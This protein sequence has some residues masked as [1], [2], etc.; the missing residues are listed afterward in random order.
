[1]KTAFKVSI[2][3]NIK[4]HNEF[5]LTLQ[6]M[7]AGKILSIINALEAQEDAQ[8]NPVAY[9]VLEALRRARDENGDSLLLG[10]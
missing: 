7:S 2:K 5:T 10:R 9:D 1:M 4:E 8:K 6:G 3:K